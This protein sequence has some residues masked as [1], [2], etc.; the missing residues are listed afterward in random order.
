MAV[1]LH[2]SQFSPNQCDGKTNDHEH[3][4]RLYRHSPNVFVDSLLKAINAQGDIYM[5]SDIF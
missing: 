4:L 2:G 3:P 5:S 1:A